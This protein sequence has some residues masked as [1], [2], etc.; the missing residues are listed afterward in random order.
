FFS[1]LRLVFFLGFFAFLLL[2]RFFLF[3]FLCLFF[4]L[5]GFLAFFLFAFFFL[6]TLFLS[7][8]SFGLR[9]RGGVGRWSTHLR[10][11]R[12]RFLSLVIQVRFRVGATGTGACH[13]LVIQRSVRLLELAHQARVASIGRVLAAVLPFQFGVDHIEHA[14]GVIRSQTATLQMG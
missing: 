4:A 1:F 7:F 11:G 12:A 6:F 3:G 2:F 10:L 14:K 13:H 8:F 5:F 9:G